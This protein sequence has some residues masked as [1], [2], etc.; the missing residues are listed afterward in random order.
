MT[1]GLKHGVALM[2][3]YGGVRCSDHRAVVMIIVV[4][5]ALGMWCVGALGVVSLT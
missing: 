4:Y 3:R 1:H 2:A 5:G